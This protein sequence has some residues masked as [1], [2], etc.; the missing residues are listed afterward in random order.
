M[1]VCVPVRFDN[2]GTVLLSSVSV[3]EEFVC[4]ILNSSHPILN[5]PRA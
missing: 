2:Y 5:F 4:L 3:F 1:R